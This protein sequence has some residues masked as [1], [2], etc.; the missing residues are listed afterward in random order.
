MTTL[1]EIID[2]TFQKSLN[3]E[4]LKELRKLGYVEDINIDFFF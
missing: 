4:L 3:Y 1:L 2:K